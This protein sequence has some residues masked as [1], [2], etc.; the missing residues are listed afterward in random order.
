MKL[1]VACLK[2]VEFSEINYG[3]CRGRIKGKNGD[4]LKRV[5]RDKKREKK[6]KITGWL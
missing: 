1:N 5:S 6:I 3:M 4:L 2:N